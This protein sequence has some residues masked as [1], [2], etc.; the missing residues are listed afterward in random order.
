MLNVPFDTYALLH[1]NVY[2]K[3]VSANST[4]ILVINIILA[5]NIKASNSIARYGATSFMSIC[6]NIGDYTSIARNGLS[7]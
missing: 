4:L 3:Y 7:M 1:E 6:N 5:V 2:S